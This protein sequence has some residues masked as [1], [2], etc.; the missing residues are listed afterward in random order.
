MFLWS[1]LVVLATMVILNL[2]RL[3]LVFKVLY[4]HIDYGKSANLVN[5][6]VVTMVTVN[7]VV[8]FLRFQGQLNLCS[9]ILLQMQMQMAIVSYSCIS[10]VQYAKLEEQVN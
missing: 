7:L 9:G 1:L 6:I 8:I 3:F 2:T 4:L 10:I 5:I